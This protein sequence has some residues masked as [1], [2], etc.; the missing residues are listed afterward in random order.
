MAARQTPNQAAE[1]ALRAGGSGGSAASSNKRYSRAVTWEASLD[2]VRHRSE[3]RAWYIAGVSWLVTVLLGVALVVLLPLKTTVP[4]VVQVE[5]ATGQTEIVS[6]LTMRDIPQRELAEKYWAKKYVIA[7][8][9]Y[10]WTILQMDY[11]NV[12]GMSS[13]DVGAQ[14]TALYRGDNARDKRLGAGVE[15]RVRIISVTLPPDQVGK[16]VVRFERLVRRAN[17]EAVE[18]SS[19]H[20]ATVA[21]E[22]RPT[23][24]GREREL[25]DNPFGFT[26]TAYRIDDE[27]AKASV[28]Q[29]PG[30][31]K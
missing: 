6:P 25:V 9:S 11:D 10:F 24:Y 31:A 12:I 21:Y 3:K 19:T 15:E 28:E 4:Y 13:P 23:K 27:I 30:D 20:V 5:R 18:Q 17:S 26:V 22:F 14:Y 29:K 16:A 7:R 1:L 8:E 2:E